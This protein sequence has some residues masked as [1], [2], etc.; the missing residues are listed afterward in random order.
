MAIIS[1]KQPDPDSSQA[2]SQTS[3]QPKDEVLA[4]LRSPQPDSSRLS[5]ER[6]AAETHRQEE[7][8]RPQTLADYIGQKALKEV[9]NIAIQAA[10]SRQEPLDHL[11]LY[12]PP[13]LG[14]TT[15]AL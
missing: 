2:D 15:M 6:T 3:R 7:S 10:Q 12:G 1:S 9:L 4:K 5:G 8:L 14:K 13:G 11:L